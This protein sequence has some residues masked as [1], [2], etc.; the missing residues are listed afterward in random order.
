VVE[1]TKQINTNKNKNHEVEK[2]TRKNQKQKQE[3]LLTRHRSINK[4]KGKIGSNGQPKK[5][6]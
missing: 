4:P 1:E 3:D 6:G 5:T 2:E